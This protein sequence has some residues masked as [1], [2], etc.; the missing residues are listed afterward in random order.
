[1]TVVSP[2][3]LWTQE[4]GKASLQSERDRLVRFCAYLTGDPNAAEDLAQEALLEAWRTSDRIREPGDFSSW[5]NGCARN[6]CKRWATQRGRDRSLQPLPFTPGETPEIAD[7]FDLEL[8]LERADL[9]E[10]LDRAL[11]LLPS[12][13]RDA[14]VQRYVEERSQAE[15]ADSLGY[16]EGTV[17]VRIHRGKL[18]LKNALGTRELR[19]LA[20]SFGLIPSQDDGWRETRIWC[21][22]CGR[23]RL[24]GTIGPE[25]TP[26]R[27][28][29]PDCHQAKDWYMIN[30]SEL[31]H[32]LHGIKTFKP[33]FARCA[34]YVHEHHRDSLA[35]GTALCL[36]CGFTN[37]VRFG[38][39]HHTPS[40]FRD[41]H[42][43]HYVCGNCQMCEN[44]ALAAMVLFHPEGQRFQREHQRIRLLPEYQIETDGVSAIVTTFESLA[45]SAR[46]EMVS[47]RNTFAPMRINGQR[48]G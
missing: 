20:A 28:R 29:C 3:N 10:L 36:V 13:T 46:F 48:I 11:G 23:F 19:P 16:T 47:S 41:D 14:L 18:A 37:A 25:G 6:V 27:F 15:I 7:D 40:E 43:F 2:T 30:G 44:F 5:L 26:D 39:G 9:A 31:H 34:T 33:A 22:I 17:A 32:V 8:E 21:P 24:L 35:V 4:T 42:G 45:N 1:M 12:D 38:M